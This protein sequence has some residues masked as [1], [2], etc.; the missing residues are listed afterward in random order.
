MDRFIQF[1]LAA[2]DEALTQA[3]WRPVSEED[4]HRT[5]RATHTEPQY[6]RSRR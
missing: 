3:G 2:A 4:R 6:S 5:G 1:A